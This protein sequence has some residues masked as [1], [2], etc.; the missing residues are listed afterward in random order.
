MNFFRFSHRFSR[1]QSLFSGL[2]LFIGVC[3]APTFTCAQITRDQTPGESA[4]LLESVNAQIAAGRAQLERNQ[5]A[6][7]ETLRNA[8]QKSLK[9]LVSY[10]GPGVLT[11]AP[12][13]MPTTGFLAAAV[14]QTALAHYW[15]GRAADHFGRRDEAVAALARAARFSGRERPN[16][17]DMLARDSRLALGAALR[18]GLPLIAPDDT[19][20]T[21]AEIAHGKLWQPRRFG[22][23]TDKATFEPHATPKKIE[24]EF[25]ITS[26]RVY[27]PVPF[28]ATDVAAALSR[29]PPLYRRVPPEALPA[30]LRLD[31]M[32][33]G[34]QKQTAAPGKGLWRQVVRVFYPSTFL[35]RGQRDDRARAETLAAQFLKV[36]ALFQ[37]AMNLQNPYNQ[38]DITTLWLSEVSAL[39]PRD[40]S[41]PRV[42]NSLGII[43]PRVNTPISIRG[44]ES[45]ENIEIAVSPTSYP[46]RGGS[47]KADF[48]PDD[49]VLFT[50]STARAEST[51]LRE[52]LHEYGHVATPPID[53]FAPPLEP[54]AN[55]A[56]GET[57]GTLWAADA[58][59]NWQPEKTFG[60]QDDVLNAIEEFGDQL[61]GQVA[62]QALP[63]LQAWQTNGPLSKLRR[64]GSTPGLQYLQGLAV[65]IERTYGAAVLGAAFSP[66]LEKHL[67][68]IA[69]EKSDSRFINTA[70][71]DAAARNVTGADTDAA[72]ATEKTADLTTDSLVATF[73][74]ALRDPFATGGVAPSG[75]LPVWLPGALEIPNRNAS[76]LIARAN[77]KLQAGARV[78]GWFFVPPAANVLHIEW[79]AAAPD[80][81]GFDTAAK[82]VPARVAQSATYA[83]DLDLKNRNGWQRISLFAKADVEVVAAQF[84]K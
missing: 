73:A 81:L 58:P 62:S 48:S 45:Q 27:P 13:E 40:D 35:T 67:A 71:Q 39:W 74:I 34:Y 36:H 75:V 47:E 8:A 54:Y 2:A 26:G 49:I 64:D 82:A 38:N 53:G 22:F 14:Q 15:W 68:T 46:W 11:A 69:S 31:R 83:A 9:A 29:V 43:M 16:S 33:V 41:D 1:C 52:I 23:A 51:W 63:A 56:L 6:S 57:L 78:G 80:A 28:G 55:G 37:N 17:P 25:L 44:S 72:S 19:L 76:D 42:R 12:E 21:I 32:V 70:A 77:L 84:E 66:L 65:Y 61:N 24:H 30:V 59:Q 20:A 4:K 5:D 79:K 18:D 3:G 10:M 7:V 50:P 60:V